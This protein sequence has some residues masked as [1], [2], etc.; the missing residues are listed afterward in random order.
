MKQVLM[1]V[2]VIA[3]STCT[4]KNPEDITVHFKVQNMTVSTVGLL[5]GPTSA[6]VV[7][8]DKNGEGTITLSG[9]NNVYPH[10]VYGEDVKDIF[11][12][13]GDEVT[14]SFDAR[15]FREGIRFEGKNAA[16]VDYLNTTRIA[17]VGTEMYGLPFEDYRK[18]IEE[19]TKEAIVLLKARKLESVNPSFVEVEEGR[20]RYVY[21]QS[22]IMY[23]MGHLY[24]TN[25]TTYRAGDEYYDFLSGLVVEREELVDVE[26]YQEFMKEAVY[27]LS[28]RGGEQA[29]DYY[30]KTVIKMK[31]IAGNFKNEKVKQVLLTSLAIDYIQRYGIGNITDLQNIY[32]AYVTDPLLRD[33]FKKVYDEYDY[34]A[35]GRLSP[36][37]KAKDS[38]GKTYT[39]KDFKGKYLYIDMWATWCGPCKQELPYLKELE[40]KFRNKNITFLG[41]S[42]DKDRAAWN[43]MVKADQLPGTQLLL[44]P[45]SKFQ[46]D[47]NIEGIPHFILLD[48]E[49][50]IVNASML[51]PSSEDVE[52]VLNALPGM[53]K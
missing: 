45:G 28:E 6:S 36:D 8:L 37:F 33:S 16:V 15:K 17:E 44:G 9:L 53:E 31:Y 39:L 19:K 18:K 48:P 46:R 34:S 13:K 35:V 20:I 27:L 42:T 38:D 24:I 49:G 30:G 29:E 32:N 21:A 26:A 25:D 41:L 7:Q 23:P 10:V 14:I 12:Q 4:R 52:R 2:L 50:K 11:L 40:Q 43:E 22:F 47:Y 5:F 3:L 1:L 51:R